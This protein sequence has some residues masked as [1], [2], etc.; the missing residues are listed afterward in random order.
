MNLNT[1]IGDVM[2]SSPV[3]LDIES[4]A[5][6]AQVM[7]S[8]KGI[9]HLPITRDDKPVSIITDR[10]INL[11]MAATKDLMRA[12]ELL[13]E[14]VCALQTYMVEES[15]PLVEVVGHMAKTQIGSTIITRNGELAGI[16]TVTDAC[17]L[18]SDCLRVPG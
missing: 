15:T 2:T 12:D 1:T 5:A 11:A 13:I 18:L 6:Q 8:D 9:R 3:S 7:M 14:D 17:R 16:F 10:D 4:S